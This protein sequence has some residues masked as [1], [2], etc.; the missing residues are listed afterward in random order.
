MHRWACYFLLLGFLTAC[1][2]T[3]SDTSPTFL[4]PTETSELLTPSSIPPTEESGPPTPT[5]VDEPIL[6][7][8]VTFDGNECTV[9]GP[10][11]VSRGVYYFIL[12]DESDK[13]LQLW[14]NHIL[15]D[16]T[17]EDLLDWQPEPGVYVPHPSWIEHPR[18]TYSLEAKITVHFLDQVG[19]YATL[20]GGYNPSSLWF[21][22]PFRVIEVE[23]E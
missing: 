22:E 6:F 2:S 16:K 5:L 4:L 19:N 15:E 7:G 3:Q 21:C 13:N 9:E 10:E 8:E 11:E 23:G 12:N 18:S 20:V 1:S 14:I 17:F